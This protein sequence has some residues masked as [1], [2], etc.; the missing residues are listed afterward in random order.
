[1]VAGGMQTASNQA[2]LALRDGLLARL[3]QRADAP[4]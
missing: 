3:E 4:A 2:L 1:M